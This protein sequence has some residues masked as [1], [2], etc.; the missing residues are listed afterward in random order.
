MWQSGSAG[1]Q[2]EG[3]T[4]HIKFG[5]IREGLCV[6]GESQ[7]DLQLIELRGDFAHGK[8]DLRNRVAGQQ[9]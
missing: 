8:P 9:A 6:L 1:H 3:D 4:Q 2:C 7:I 5:L